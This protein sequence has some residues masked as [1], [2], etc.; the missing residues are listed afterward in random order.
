MTD[1]FKCGTQT[2]KTNSFVYELDQKHD[3]LVIFF[4]WL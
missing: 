1:Y 4:F 2:L 3:S